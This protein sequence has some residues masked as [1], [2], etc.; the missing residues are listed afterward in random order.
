M[1]V[2]A[3]ARRR[4]GVPVVDDAR[5]AADRARR[6]RRA[7]RGARPGHDAARRRVP[8]P[9]RARPRSRER[10]VAAGAIDVG[11]RRWTTSPALIVTA[12]DDEVALVGERDRVRR[13]TSRPAS[14]TRTRRPSVAD[15][16][17]A[18]A[19]TLVEVGEPRVE[20]AQ[21]ARRAARSRSIARAVH[22]CTRWRSPRA[23]PGTRR[24]RTFSPMPTTTAPAPSR[25]GEDPRELAVVDDD[26][27]RPLQPRV[28][29]GRARAPRR[30]RRAPAASV[31]RCRRSGGERGPEQHRDEERRARRRD[32]RCG[33][34]GP[35][36]RS[37]RR[38]PRP[39]PR[40]A[41][42]AGFEQR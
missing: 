13:R 4:R 8:R 6:R 23:R 24:Q 3:L 1:P 39:R 42:R 33:R 27:V 15:R 41:P 38:R 11:R 32:P 16:A 20:R 22:G 10:S 29:A 14:S 28:D 40:R 18:S 25:L 9:R 26:V 35:G 12:V 31:T 7:A 37:A 17:V 5:G 21:P 30:P 36:P 19:T 34:A 2:D